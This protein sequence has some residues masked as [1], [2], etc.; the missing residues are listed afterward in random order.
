MPLCAAQHI[1]E[2]ELSVKIADVY[3][4][5]VDD[6]NILEPGKCQVGEDLA[7]KAPSTDDQDLALVAQELLDLGGYICSQIVLYAR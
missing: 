4:I 1:P 7:A 6:M 2:E 3:G 5:H